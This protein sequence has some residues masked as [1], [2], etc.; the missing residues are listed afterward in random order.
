MEFDG[1]DEAREEGC[2]SVVSLTST[3][4][5]TKT[6]CRERQEQQQRRCETNMQEPRAGARREMSTAAMEGREQAQMGVGE[7]LGGRWGW[8]MRK[9]RCCA[10]QGLGW[11]GKRAANFSGGGKRAK[12][13]SSSSCGRFG[14]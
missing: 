13:H 12:P 8:R 14:P 1:R 6:E 11:G 5:G 10:S 4:D 9:K 2:G 3:V 7:K